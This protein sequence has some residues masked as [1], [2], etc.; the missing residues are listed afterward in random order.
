MVSP[1]KGSEKTIRQFS[2]K[3]VAAAMCKR[4]VQRYILEGSDSIVFLQYKPPNQQVYWNNPIHCRTRRL[5][6]SNFCLQLE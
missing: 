6:L 2:V 3:K 5:F 1:Q 4:E